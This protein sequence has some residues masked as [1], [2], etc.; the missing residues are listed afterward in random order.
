MQQKTRPTDMLR[1]LPVAH[2]VVIGIAAVV[3]IMA[4]FL[5]FQWVSTPTY[6]VLYTGLDDQTLATVVDELEQQGVPYQ[7]EAGGS[8]VLVPKAQVY[9]VR[10]DL[11]AAGVRSGS[12]PEG[13]EL[14]D[15]EGLSVS[16]F[17]Q[18]VDYQRALE[19]ELA[20]TLIAMNDI[21]SATVHLVLPEET[22]FVEDEE[23]VTASV[24]VHPTRPLGELEIETITFLVASSVEGLDATNVTVADVDG[25]VLHAAGDLTGG[26]A[27]SNRNLRMTRDF[28]QSLAT[29]V[30]N[31]LASV[32]GPNSASVVVRAQLDFDEESVESET[33]DP[34]SSTA[35][36]EQTIEED[37][38]GAGTPPGGTLGVDGQPLATDDGESYTYDRSEA[39]REFGV[40]RVVSRTITA[41]GRVEH[42]SVAVVVD[43]GS[44]TGAPVPTLN[45][46]QS[47]VS[48][49]VGLDAERGDTISVTAVAFPPLEAADEAEA[50]AD[51]GGFD[52]L[53]LLP[54]AIGALVMLVVAAALFLMARA[55]K[56]AEE[57][58]IIDEQGVVALP[59][60]AGQPVPRSEQPEL[61]GA[62]GIRPE[63][64]SMVQ[65]QPEEIAVLL[66]SWLADRR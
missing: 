40:D 34:E 17:R 21:S 48:A 12:V 65:K 57:Q 33:Y 47:L 46:V 43:D 32:S 64:M 26:S 49:A 18:R 22:L 55:G 9:K 63:V 25:Q 35:L 6:T 61:V 3:L 11:A 5:F 44:L 42:L 23:A 20:R 41:P 59:A 1:A 13:Y 62:G 53:A 24:L 54:Q 19:G 37:F 4:A 31:L 56:P 16:D 14:L 28:E 51:A 39:I 45:E 2:Q 50:A 10:G 15:G 7:L 60:P 52:P 58:L 66:R 30:R 36:R 27:M 38:V 29:D 8:R